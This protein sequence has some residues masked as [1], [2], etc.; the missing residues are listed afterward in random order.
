M[1]HIGYMIGQTIGTQLQALEQLYL[2]IP[3]I[4]I[5]STTGLRLIQSP[6]ILF[7]SMLPSSVLLDSNI[8]LLVK[9]RDNYR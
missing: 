6:Q 2:L 3:K 4:L 9:R 1:I 5:F 7:R 8:I